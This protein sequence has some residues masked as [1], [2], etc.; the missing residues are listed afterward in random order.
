MSHFDPHPKAYTLGTS[1]YPLKYLLSTF[2]SPIWTLNTYPQGSRTVFK[3][4]CVSQGALYTIYE[5]CLLY[6]LVLE[7]GFYVDRF[8]RASHSPCVSLYIYAQMSI[9]AQGLPSPF[10]RI[11]N[12]L[13][14]SRLSLRLSFIL[15]SDYRLRLH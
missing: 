1:Q 14:H 4:V 5:T 15:Q 9:W 6:A 12:S 3:T 7:I 8:T 2:F 11:K 10:L 13:I